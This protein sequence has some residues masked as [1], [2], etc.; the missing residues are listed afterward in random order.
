MQS[1]PVFIL[2][3]ILLTPAIAYGSCVSSIKSTLQHT[4]GT[5]DPAEP[6][7]EDSKEAPKRPTPESPGWSVLDSRFLGFVKSGG[8][9]RWHVDGS[10]TLWVSRDTGAT[11]NPDNTAQPVGSGLV[12]TNGT[13]R[14][15]RRFRRFVM[16]SDFRAE[17]FEGSHEEGA[18]QRVLDTAVMPEDAPNSYARAMSCLD[19]LHSQWGGRD[20][21]TNTLISNNLIFDSGFLITD[22]LGA[23]RLSKPDGWRIF[24]ADWLGNI[25]GSTAGA[26]SGLILA[27]SETGL[28][29]S[30]AARTAVA[31]GLVQFQKDVIYREVLDTGGDQTA[32][33]IADFD[34]KYFFLLRLP[35]SHMTDKFIYND[36]PIRLFDACRSGARITVRYGPKV[37]RVVERIGS[38]ILYYGLRAEIVGK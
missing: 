16:Q 13:L 28:L 5:D 1:A 10:G 34:R 37:V 11:C 24:T 36:L 18:N 33:Q 38:T 9:G 26:V 12:A 32:Y 22:A 23:H 19:T 29:A 25:V 2:V 8:S 14:F 7:R 15:D 4:V 31:M 3:S 6:I 30:F 17:P 20:F 27:R 21:V 35:M